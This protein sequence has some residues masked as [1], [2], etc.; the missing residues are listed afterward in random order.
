VVILEAEG[1]LD[2]YSSTLLLSSAD[3]M[4]YLLLPCIVFLMLVPRAEPSFGIPGTTQTISG[5]DTELGEDPICWRSN[6]STVDGEIEDIPFP[7]PLVKNFKLLGEVALLRECPG[8]NYI[9]GKA[10]PEFQRGER[11]RTGEIYEYSVSITLEIRS[12]GGNI[13]VSDEGPLIGVQILLCKL[14]AGFCS[15][16]IHEEANARLATQGILTPPSKGDSHGG[17]HTHSGYNFF[18]V[19]PEDGPIYKLDVTIPMLVNTAGEYFAVASVQMYVGD[20]LEEPATERYDMAN[21][22]L[23]NQR[24]ITYQEPADIMEV[25]DGVLIVSY[26][27]IGVVALV[28]LFLLVETIKNRNHQVLRLTQGYFLIVF[29]IS[30]LVMVVSSFLFAPK[31]DHYCNASFPIVLIS[32]QLLYAITIGRLWRINAVISPLL[33]HSLRQKTGWTSRMMEY[34]KTV[35]SRNTNS[36]RRRPKNLRKQISHWQLGLVVALFTLPQVIIQVLSFTLQPQ[37]RTIDY[38]E[39][40]SQGRATCDSGFDMKS[41]LRDYGFWVFILLIVLLLFMAQATSQ[42]PSLFNETKVIYE[43]AL[44]SI[45]LLVLGMG[46]I[47]VTDDP[48]TSPSVTYLVAV[49]WTLSIALNTSLRIMLPK[50]RMVWRNEKVVVSKLVSDHAKSVREEDMRFSSIGTVSGLSSTYSQSSV[51]VSGMY[52]NSVELPDVVV[53]ECDDTQNHEQPGASNED[54]EKMNSSPGGSAD[55]V[56]PPTP[57]FPPPETPKSGNNDGDSKRRAHALTPRK[58][59]PSSRILVQCDEPPSRRLL[60]KMVDLQQQLSEINSR[61]MSGLAVSEEEWNTVRTMSSKLGSTFKDDV[62]FAWDNDRADIPAQSKVQGTAK[63]E[64]EGDLKDLS[65]KVFDRLVG[66]SP[67]S[68]STAHSSVVRFQDEDTNGN[69]AATVEEPSQDSADAV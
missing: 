26:V 2:N 30:A 16:F 8:L 33:M 20:G 22:F 69:E 49:V 1:E 10:P 37:L 24:L 31:N 17:T 11:L 68:G 35:T 50:L 4:M 23:L 57:Q 65:Q 19:A 39:D 15:P 54:T 46:I 41:S 66:Q 14:G 6:A 60:L 55:F 51:R 43:S 12:L 36:R 13:F 47:V 9:T 27:A 5:Y 45:V 7:N 3:P 53:S 44:F 38:N 52:S 29:L 40:E 32:A 63:E 67:K 18:K 59:T 25:P 62:D 64:T 34:L 28:I 48:T 58:R 56:Q 42:L 61:I 21:A